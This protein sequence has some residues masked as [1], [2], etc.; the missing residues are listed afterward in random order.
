MV[1][2]LNC[3]SATGMP[4]VT[5]L[6]ASDTLSVPRLLF[7]SR[8]HSGLLFRYYS[9]SLY[10]NHTI[11]KTCAFSRSE[12]K[13]PFHGNCMAALKTL[14]VDDVKNRSKSRV[15]TSV[16][17]ALD[18]GGSQNVSPR[19]KRRPQL[20][21]LRQFAKCSADPTYTR[22]RPG[23]YLA[24]CRRQHYHGKPVIGQR[25]HHAQ[26]LFEVYRLGDI[27]AAAQLVHFHNFLLVR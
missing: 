27:R 6:A 19:G 26:K 16:E 3:S 12:G 8:H 15:L 20:R 24:L 13:L 14:L 4:S 10:N 22:R 23:F 7:Q 25:L 9:L 5:L 2:E 18:L 11:S 17:P 21:Q 1:R